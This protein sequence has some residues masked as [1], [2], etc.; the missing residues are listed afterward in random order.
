MINFDYTKI[1]DKCLPEAKHLTYEVRDL[2][3][4]TKYLVTTEFG[5]VEQFNKIN[6]KKIANK[7]IYGLYIF[8][9]NISFN[10]D[11]Y[12]FI[13]SP[14]S[15]NDIDIKYCTHGDTDNYQYKYQLHKDHLMDFVDDLEEEYEIQNK[16]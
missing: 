7:M 15:N 14:S 4:D 3:E 8:E 2:D 16:A 11:H 1:I 13:V 10:S 9:N 5:D 12:F 6:N